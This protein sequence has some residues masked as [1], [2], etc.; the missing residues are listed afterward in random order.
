MP[1]KEYFD[2]ANSDLNEIVQGGN[3]VELKHSALINLTNAI[4]N[5][6][7]LEIKDSKVQIRM[8]INVMED[9]LENPTYPIGSANTQGLISALAQ[10]Y[11]RPYVIIDNCLITYGGS[12]ENFSSDNHHEL[13]ELEVKLHEYWR[14]TRMHPYLGYE[15]E[16]SLK[17]IFLLKQDLSFLPYFKA[18]D[19]IQILVIAQVF[20][21]S[22]AASLFTSP[23]AMTIASEILTSNQRL[24]T[25]ETSDSLQ[26]SNAMFG[27][28][29]AQPS[30]QPSRPTTS[31]PTS[32]PSRRPGN[33]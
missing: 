21:L 17:R 28:P 20:A 1:F 5:L 25:S 22:L 29:S 6:H 19:A 24:T 26:N 11:N 2:L 8:A 18:I 16:E 30:S 4:I 9:Y 3:E 27:Q 31:Q 33:S 13:D 32:Q 23:T 10:W 7:P 15:Q 14:N 12:I